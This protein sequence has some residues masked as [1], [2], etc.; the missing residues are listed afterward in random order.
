MKIITLILCMHSEPNL[1]Q[2]FLYRLYNIV[3]NISEELL[4]HTDHINIF[5][6]PYKHE[7]WTLK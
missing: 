2:I 1:F 5:H 4:C 3:L 7:E 6:F